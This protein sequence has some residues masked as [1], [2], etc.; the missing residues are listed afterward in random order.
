MK[1]GSKTHA[2][3]FFFIVCWVTIA[4]AAVAIGLAVNK[5]VQGG[6][7]M[8]FLDGMRALF[9]G[10]IGATGAAAG[11]MGLFSRQMKRCRIMGLILLV[12]SA[13]PLIVDLA[14][15]KPFSQ[16]WLSALY[17]V[18]PLLYFIGSLLKRSAKTPQPAQNAQ[19]AEPVQKE[20]PKE[21]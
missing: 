19:P 8:T 21:Q 4:A 17:I 15:K 10:L 2:E 1:T 13:I 5:F 14:G 9:G 3:F 7:E 6:A 11:F 16:Y 20:T 18:L 12:L